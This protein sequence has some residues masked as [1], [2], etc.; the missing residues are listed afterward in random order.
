[1][2]GDLVRLDAA[3]QRDIQLDS[4]L[5]AC[6][7]ATDAGRTA[8][9][10][11]LLAPTSDSIELTK[12][13]NEI[14]AIRKRCRDP[15]VAA[16]IREA[17]ETLRAT[18]AD[19]LSIAEARSDKRNAEYYNQILWSPDSI[20]AALNRHGWLTELMVAFRTLILPAL[21][22]V[23]PLFVLLAPLF[24]Y[25]FVMK[26]PL[27]FSEYV[28]MLQTSMKG[29][30][31]SVLGKPRFAGT[32]GAL[33]VGEQFLHIGAAI[34]MF[35]ASIWNQIS[36]A[37]TMRGV[38]ADMRRRA[39]AVRRATE[40]AE[41]LAGALGIT[42]TV[43]LPR[44]SAGELG[45]F[46]DGW[47]DP[48]LIRGLLDTVGRLD[49]LASVAGLRRVAFVTWG[50]HVNLQQ[51]YHPSLDAGRRVYNSVIAGG[52]SGK[53]PHIL[54]TGPNRGGKS[55]LLKSLGAAV[56]M[57]QTFGV[58][59][60]RRAT[61]P[62]FGHIITALQPA[63]ALGKMS[64]F[65]AEIEFAKEVQRRLREEAERGPMF[66]MMDEIFHGTNA[67]DGLEASQVFLDDLY[68]E[69]AVPVFSVVSTHYMGLP[70]RYGGTQTQNLCMDAAKDP[71]DPDRLIYTYKL[72]EG[73]NQFSSVREILAERG[74]LVR[75]PCGPA[76]EKTPAPASK[77]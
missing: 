31:P 15:E 4:L 58:V 65:E 38:V 7:P 40:A 2:S 76:E 42:E 41:R 27:T 69:H 59:F 39:D 49:M 44:W 57:S 18:E 29:A 77:A 48:T 21:S 34:A 67:H 8:L 64:L 61:L 24:I 47:N 74:L 12:R 45:T 17:R 73:V 3:T 72:K 23:L 46:G 60:A 1:M 20:A 32:G 26:K 6:A 70:E 10:K 33:E 11:R 13:Q 30:M 25:M 68:R 14:R 51:L 9:R 50:D 28:K 63:D 75:S 36:A 56:L 35:G 71:A 66:L 53:K 55:T 22:V 54:L 62:V 43:S 5:D 19:V 52:V 37:M 16:T